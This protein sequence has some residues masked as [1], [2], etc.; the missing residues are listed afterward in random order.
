VTGRVL[1]GIRYRLDAGAAVAALECD[2]RSPYGRGEHGYDDGLARVKASAEAALADFM[3]ESGPIFSAPSNGYSFEREQDGRVLFSY[4]VDG[5][6][7]VSMFAA[8]GVR[9][10]NGD[11][12]WGVRAWAQCDLSELPA[13][14]TD[15]LNIGVWV[16]GS[17][18][19]V[20]VTRIQS[21]QGAEHCSWTDLTFLLI[22]PER[23]A[24]WYVRGTSADFAG[25]LGTTFSSEAALP[26]G[27]TD[28]R[29]RRGDRQLW[30]GRTGRPPTWW[31]S[32]MRMTSSAGRRPSG[33]SRARERR[34]LGHTPP[35]HN[36]EPPPAHSIPGRP[37]PRSSRPGHR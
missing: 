22:G 15:D 2:G 23:S 35:L 24:D 21:F 13:A 10:W 32:T 31:R 34:R 9:D 25:L 8:D 18:R 26:E 20:P 27:A 33:R 4:D 28:T 17:G 5:R 6:T 1:A 29:L 19:R 16:D 12:G 7:K 14:V 3:R 37:S 36:F 30:I 11:Q